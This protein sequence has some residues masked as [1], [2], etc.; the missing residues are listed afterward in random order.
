VALVS[1]A[2]DGVPR[3]GVVS[4]GLVAKTSEP[5]PVS[6]VT[7]AAR[8]KLVGVPKKVAMP[9]PRPETPVLIGRPV[10]FV[11]VR[12][13]GVPRAGLT[14]TGLFENTTALLPV[15]P[16]TVTPPSVIVLLPLLIVLLDNVSVVALPTRVSVVL[17]NVIVNA[18]AVAGA[19]IEA[20]PPPEDGISVRVPATLDA[21]PTVSVPPDTVKFALPETAL[22][23]AL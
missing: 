12:T 20:V 18:L 4:V 16:E 9:V 3:L 5:E 14:R 13:E 1:V 23:D 8:L 2:A 22:V 15:E 17:G 19:T 7:V 6:S 10:A 11:R 21:R